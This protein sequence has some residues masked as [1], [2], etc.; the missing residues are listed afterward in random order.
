MQQQDMY[1]RLDARHT[2]QLVRLL[3]VAKPNRS[4]ASQPKNAKQLGEKS[5]AANP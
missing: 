3:R 1:L 2:C 5:V 4:A